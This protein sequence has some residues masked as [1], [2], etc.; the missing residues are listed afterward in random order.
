[1]GLAARSQNQ[2]FNSTQ[3]S[4]VVATKK[5]PT[6]PGRREDADPLENQSVLPLLSSSQ[7][8]TDTFPSHCSLS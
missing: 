5:P 7:Q 2:L 3:H 1:M 6:P 8:C 4:G